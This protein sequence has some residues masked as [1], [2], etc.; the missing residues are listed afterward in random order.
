M[1]GEATEG[2]AAEQA[3]EFEVLESGVAVSALAHH[4]LEAGKGV[5]RFPIDGERVVVVSIPK[6]G[7]KAD[8]VRSALDQALN[9][10]N[11]GPIIIEDRRQ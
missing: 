8:F 1:A 3:G 4:A 11:R 10:A 7:N 9:G 5:A 2:F 6:S